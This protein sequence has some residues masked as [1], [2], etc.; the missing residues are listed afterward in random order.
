MEF[1][2]NAFG[3]ILGLCIALV[4]VD[5]LVMMLQGKEDEEDGDEPVRKKRGGGLLRPWKGRW[6]L[7]TAVVAMIAGAL[8]A[9]V[10]CDDLCGFSIGMMSVVALLC[11]FI[12]GPVIGYALWLISRIIIWPLRAVVAMIS[13]KGE[14]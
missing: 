1:L 10:V 9:A 8:S 5:I 11:V 12:G 6:W 14:E 13:W 2:S 3:V 4:A 7:G